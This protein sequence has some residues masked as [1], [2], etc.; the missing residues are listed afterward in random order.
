MITRSLFFVHFLIFMIFNV[1]SQ[2]T[3]QE[4]LTN[5]I[6][7]DVA[8]NTG[9]DLWAVGLGGTLLH[10][11]GN[12]WIRETP[13]AGNSFNRVA[14]TAPDE[15]WAI[16]IEGKVFH[17][18]GDSWSLHFTA[19][20]ALYT[21]YFLESGEGFI[22]GANG[23][24]AFYNGSEWVAG[25]IGYNASTL[26]SYFS[27]D[28]NGW[29]SAGV[30]KMYQ[31]KDSI[32]SE[33]DI[34]TTGAFF[35][36]SFVSPNNGYAVGFDNTIWHYDGNTWALDYTS[37]T[38]QHQYLT[39]VYFLDEDHGWASGQG[40][41]FTYRYGI[42]Y[43]E[44]I[45]EDWE[46]WGFQ[47]NDPF[48][49][50]VVGS[51]GLILRFE[52]LKEWHT[53]TEISNDWY[54]TEI[55]RDPAGTFFA[56][57]H[58]ESNLIAESESCLYRSTDG[59]VWERI[60]SNL[61]Q[62][63]RSY[64]IKAMGNVLLASVM[65]KEF[66][67]ELFRSEDMGN[68]W[69]SSGTG[70]TDQTI[71]ED[72]AVNENGIL[73]AVANHTSPELYKSEDQGNSWSLMSTTGFSLPTNASQANFVSI[74]AKGDQLFIFHQDKENDLND[75]YT[76]TNET[77]W[78]PL[79]TNPNKVFVA[80]LH[81]DENGILYA[82][83]AI[84]DNDIKGVVMASTDLGISWYPINADGLGDIFVSIAGVGDELLLS[85]YNGGISPIF[86]L[87]TT[88]KPAPQAINF[89]PLNSSMYG[90]DSFELTAASSSGLTVAFQSSN[91]AVASVVDQ[92][93]IINGAGEAMITASQPGNGAFNP[94]ENVEQLLTVEKATLSVRVENVIRDEGASNPNFQ[95]NY[96]GWVGDDTVDDID[97][98]PTALCEANEQSAAGVY[99]IVLSGGEDNN[100]EFSYT[101]GTLTIEL[102]TSLLKSK[103]N[104]MSVYPNPVTNEL[105]VSQGKALSISMSVYDLN[106]RLLHKHSLD[107]ENQV[108]DFSNYSK[109][110]YLVEFISKKGIEVHQIIKN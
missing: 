82:A 17:F 26:T 61:D 28:K 42:W 68:T 22:S 39:D 34:S 66:N 57:G 84:V 27:D 35:E 76:S 12:E 102:I 105:V 106:G 107:R 6:L 21:L 65:D 56:I 52:E 74:E 31:F 85:S 97:V 15:G 45:D 98:Q 25:N 100:Y 11:D 40:T 72:I 38:N 92:A 58:T 7:Y 18:D 44:L 78:T 70:L 110:T 41:M 75:I 79:A 4:A 5:Q 64:T 94:A 67:W 60:V 49:G 30:G 23:Y 37:S 80:D 53:I 2:W 9:N 99:P 20:K 16:T 90:D 48:D 50:W 77:D 69:T 104:L 108:I 24:L 19:E 43:E 71:V 89:D 47:F 46:I 109:G 3:V 13:L 103:E 8:S 1:Q 10:Y 54:I 32:W 63:A 81:F 101:P 96:T 33:I 51:D 95:L 29:L 91:P 88:L 36:M 62:M 14:F 59:L 86:K 87:F 73:F 93:I 83:G 55:T